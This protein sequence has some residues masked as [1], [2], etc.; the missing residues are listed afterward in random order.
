[1]VHGGGGG[2][3]ARGT[4]RR[5]AAERTA[6]STISWPMREMGRLTGPSSGVS[7]SRQWMRYW[8]GFWWGARVSGAAS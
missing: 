6:A 7:V 8:M 4:A 1:M 2:Y 5:D 3:Q